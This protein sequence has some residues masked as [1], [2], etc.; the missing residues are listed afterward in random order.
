MNSPSKSI[1]EQ[2]LEAIELI[3]TT[4]DNKTYMTR[5]RIAEVLERKHSGFKE[6]F[7]LSNPNALLF[8]LL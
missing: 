8:I 6:N 2:L 1:Q 3:E 4:L 7:Y 5:L